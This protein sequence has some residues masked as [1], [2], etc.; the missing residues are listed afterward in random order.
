MFRRLFL[1]ASG[2]CFLLT[3]AL[4]AW[5]PIAQSAPYDSR[6]SICD[7]SLGQYGAIYLTAVPAAIELYHSQAELCKQCGAPMDGA[8]DLS[9]CPVKLVIAFYRSLNEHFFALPGFTFQSYDIAYD[10]VQVGTFSLW[11]PLAA[12]GIGPALAALFAPFRQRRLARQ[13]GLCPHCNY[14]LTGNKSG[15]CPECG[16]PLRA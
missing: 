13:L 12:F 7:F 10:H 15:Q 4:I 5:T 16:R 2:V 11:L 3:L 14:N 1:P 6:T 8:H 9:S